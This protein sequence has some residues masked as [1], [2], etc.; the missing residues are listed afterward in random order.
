MM[1]SMIKYCKSAPVVGRRALPSR[2]G[3]EKINIRRIVR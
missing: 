1:G 2:E 3:T